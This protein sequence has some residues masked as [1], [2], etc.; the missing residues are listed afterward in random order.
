MNADALFLATKVRLW[1]NWA[2]AQTGRPGRSVLTGAVMLFTWGA[3]Y[4]MFQSGFRYAQWVHYLDVYLISGM[5]GVFFLLMLLLLVLTSV[6]QTSHGLYHAAE[7]GLLMHLPIAPAR[8]ALYRSIELSLLNSAGALFLCTPAVAAYIVVEQVPRLQ[9]VQALLLLLPL[10]VIPN[11]VGAS[12]T[13][14]LRRAAGRVPTRVFVVGGILLLL[15]SAYALLTTF[16]FGMFDE[17]EHAVRLLNQTAQ[18]L[19]GTRAW[20]LPSHWYV[21]AVFSPARGYPKMTWW[22][23]SVLATVACVCLVGWAATIRWSYYPSWLADRGAAAHAP[24]PRS[25]INRL[26]LWTRRLRPL[27][28][29]ARTLLAKDALLFVREPVV[30]T[31]GLVMAGLLLVYFASLRSL[32]TGLVANPLHKQL[33]AVMNFAALGILLSAFGARFLLPLLSLEGRKFWLLRTAPPRLSYLLLQKW[34]FSALV[35][36][37]LGQPMLALSNYMTTM[38]RVFVLASHGALLFLAPTLAAV[39]VGLGAMFPDFAGDGAQT[40][41]AATFAFVLCV[42]FLATFLVMIGVP[43]YFYTLVESLS[44]ADFLHRLA[45]NVIG[46]G[47]VGWGSGLLLMVLGHLRLNRVD[48]T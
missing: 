46:A 40:G 18:S 16:D 35:L 10:L 31:Q 38:D 19:S 12:L 27:P 8:A 4:L 39:C 15:A 42:A 43:Y 2:R 29:T 26:A 41:P 13:I 48:Q 30:R 32:Y 28:E 6:V 21:E 47:L 23:G 22:F 7:A 20:F 45:R 44:Y 5:F 36:L 25:A 11:C 9:A 37:A 17:T 1:R 34:V 24:A 33:I 3:L 14:L